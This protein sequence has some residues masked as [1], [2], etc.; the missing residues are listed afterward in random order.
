MSAEPEPS[1]SVQAAPHAA[2]VTALVVALVWVAVAVRV[3]APHNEMSAVP[4]TTRLPID[5]LP[6]RPVMQLAFARSQA[7]IDA[8]LDTAHDPERRNIASVRAGNLLDSLAPVPA[9]SLLL[10]ALTLLIARA[11]GELASGIFG[12]G[13]LLTVALALADLGENVGIA[14]ALTSA[15]RDEPMTSLARQFMVA[16]AFAKW[17]LLGTIALGIGVVTW[18]QEAKWHRW[19]STVCLVLGIWILA[20]GGRHFVGILPVVAATGAHSSTTASIAVTTTRSSSSA[21][22]AS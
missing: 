17:T 22:V 18:L 2:I 1:M 4:R 7:D 3:I 9:Y 8:I 5:S 21:P 15:E 14:A 10:I 6:E 13:V 12:A 11:S 16:S 19:L 20:T